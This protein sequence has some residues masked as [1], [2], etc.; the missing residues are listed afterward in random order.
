MTDS[1][2]SESLKKISE[3]I[4]NPGLATY[5]L[6]IGSER[7]FGKDRTA[8]ERD[9]NEGDTFA[10]EESNLD[11]TG[12]SDLHWIGVC[13]LVLASFYLLGRIIS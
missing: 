9:E 7:V 8:G 6:S 4:E 12:S 2:C 1:A 3:Y 13:L 5:K 10:G 11:I